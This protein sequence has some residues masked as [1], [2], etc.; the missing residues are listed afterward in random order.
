MSAEVLGLPLIALPQGWTP[1]DAVVV[2]KCI[3]PDGRMQLTVRYTDGLALWD[4]LG[5]LASA[6]C[7][8][9]A[10]MV[11]AWKPVSDD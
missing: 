7:T 1:V 3:D 11:G 5:L 10:D 2:A 6:T 4:V 9:E 8:T